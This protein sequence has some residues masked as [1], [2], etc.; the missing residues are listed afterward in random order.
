MSPAL[1]SPRPV[2]VVE[3]RAR[4]GRASAGWALA[5]ATALLVGPTDAL[6]RGGG[7]QNGPTASDFAEFVNAWQGRNAAGIR[8]LIP[9]KERVQIDLEGTGDGRIS[10]RSTPENA[11]AV[12]KEYFSK[13]EAPAL[14][15][16]SPDDARTTTRSFDYTYRPTGAESRTTRLSVTLRALHGGGYGLERLQERVRKP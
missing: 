12:L 1:L 4:G 3:P 2:S 13:L 9:E 15:D 16:V 11:E 5:L 6:A 10:G 8:K 14:K 7:E